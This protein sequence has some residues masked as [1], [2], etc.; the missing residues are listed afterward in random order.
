MK[1]KTLCREFEGE[2]GVEDMNIKLGQGQLEF[3]M[4]GS[5]NPKSKEYSRVCRYDNARQCIVCGRGYYLRAKSRKQVVRDLV[6][7]CKFSKRVAMRIA[8]AAGLSGKKARRCLKK[9]RLSKIRF[10]RRQQREL[11][12]LDFKRQEKIADRYLKKRCRKGFQIK[13]LNPFILD[14][15]MALFN[16]NDLLDNSRERKQCT[17]RILADIQSGDV[18]RMNKLF[19]DQNFWLKKVKMSRKKLSLMRNACKRECKRTRRC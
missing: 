5:D 4:S 1:S 6:K 14:V 7:A 18:R 8:K 11:F 2:P 10:S 13:K 12:Q 17:K 16:D 19:R 3:K 15:T 9:Y